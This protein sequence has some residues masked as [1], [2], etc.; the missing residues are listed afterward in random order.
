[1]VTKGGHHFW[2]SLRLVTTSDSI[3]SLTHVEPPSSMLAWQGYVTNHV[4][5]CGLSV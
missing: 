3:P 1:M 4:T 2:L 5:I